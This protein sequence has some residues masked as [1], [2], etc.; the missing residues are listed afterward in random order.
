MS[1]TVTV[2]DRVWVMFHFL[3]LFHCGP[4][5]MVCKGTCQMHVTGAHITFEIN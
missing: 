5:V 2:T 3:V 1:V 4:V